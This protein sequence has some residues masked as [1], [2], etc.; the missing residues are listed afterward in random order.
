MKIELKSL[1][2][3]LKKS[4]AAIF[5][6]ADLYI[7]GVNI[8]IAQNNGHAMAS[9]TARAGKEDI[10]QSAKD[11]FKALPKIKLSPANGNLEVSNSLA[12]HVDTIVNEEAK[13]K[14][15]K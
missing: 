14:H 2:I 11:Y 6:V 1:K 5:F 9:F 4:H 3:N 15:S 13:N 10:L 8:G 7:D 12:L